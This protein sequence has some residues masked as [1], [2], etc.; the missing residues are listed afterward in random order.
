M[1]AKLHRVVTRLVFVVVVSIACSAWTKGVATGDGLE[2]EAD[3]G[4]PRPV[5]SDEES[6]SN[7]TTTWGAISATAGTTESAETG[8]AAMCGDGIAEGDEVCD[9]ED[10]G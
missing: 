4:A 6:G 1:C 9:G 7:G 5:G 2:F 3:S 8:D 10:L